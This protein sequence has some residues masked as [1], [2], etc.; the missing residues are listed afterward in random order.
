M[1]QVRDEGL[2]SDSGH[3]MKRDVGGRIIR[4]VMNWTCRMREREDPKRFKKLLA[5]ITS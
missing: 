1:V 4:M 5:Y 2:K 3:Q